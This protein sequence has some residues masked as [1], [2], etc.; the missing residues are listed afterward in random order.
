[1][2]ITATVTA[3]AGPDLTVTAGVF[4]GVKSIAADPDA[5]T[6]TLT[7]PDQSFKTFSTEGVTTFSASISGKLWTVT[8]S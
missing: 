5:G 4:T 8:V 7:Y 6:I 1:M 2:S 3:N